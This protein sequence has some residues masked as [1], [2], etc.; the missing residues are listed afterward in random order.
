MPG[1]RYKNCVSGAMPGP[2][3]A[4]DDVPLMCRAGKVPHLLISDAAPPF[5]A[6]WE[7]CYWPNRKS[8]KY[9]DHASMIHLDGNGN[10]NMMESLNRELG[11]RMRP[12]RFVSEEAAAAAERVRLFYNFFHGHSGLGNR[13][14]A[15][16]AIVVQGGNRWTT[17]LRN[18]HAKVAGWRRPAPARRDGR[19]SVCAGSGFG[20]KRAPMRRAKEPVRVPDASAARRGT[21]FAANP[22]LSSALENSPTTHITCIPGV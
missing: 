4:G 6:A 8:Q 17:L 12:T 9:A 2:R 10:N 15:E 18:A 13:T 1:R 16:A 19:G 20:R 11:R 22:R 5:R 3:K 14:P 21:V 7:P